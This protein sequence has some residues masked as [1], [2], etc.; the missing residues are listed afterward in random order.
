MN[1][2][3]FQI[4]AATS[5][6][7][8]FATLVTDPRRPFET[9]DIPVPFFQALSALTGA[10]KTPILAESVQQ[11]RAH[12]V[13]EPAVIWLSK[14]RVTVD[15]TLVNLQPGGKYAALC[16]G[17]TIVALN[18]V[19]QDQMQDERTPLIIVGTVGTFNDKDKESGNLRI[20]KQRSDDGGP[21]A[22]DLLTTR[23]TASGPRPLILV[24]DEAHNLTDQQ[25]DLLMEL[26]PDVFLTASATMKT[27]GRLGRIITRLSESGWA[28]KLVTRIASRDVVGAELV[29]QQIVL[30][31]YLAS[32]E[33]AVEQMISTMRG[34]AEAAQALGVGI[35]PKAIYVC[36]TNMIEESGEKDDPRRSFP[37]RKAAPILIW[38]YLVET[39]GIDPSDIA[40]YC[41]L[42]VDKYHPLPDEFR[43]L[44]GGDN[45]YAAFQAGRYHHIIFNQSLQEG[46]DDP[47]CYFAYIDKAM[48]STI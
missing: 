13:G 43:L 38:R 45:Q 48:G 44:S 26:R 47:E 41:D 14:A 24:Y 22:W 31:G 34:C 35:Q 28:D 15:Q 11:I 32:M 9:R 27:P 46:W 37:E 40:V 29:K 2:F 33:I 6:A 12:L 5:I 39:M 30:G 25:V 8:R 16:D 18:E 20:F 23:I 4:E 10:G 17:F 7:D 36:R 3:P 19:T 42:A 21:S 1:L